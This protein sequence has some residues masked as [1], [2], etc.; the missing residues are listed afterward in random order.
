MFEKKSL[1]KIENNLQELEKKIKELSIQLE[2]A[3]KNIKNFF[4]ETGVSL[5]KLSSYSSNKENFSEE[6][7]R[8]LSD[9][10]QQL[11]DKLKLELTNI[12]NPLKVKRARSSLQV[13]RHW[14]YVR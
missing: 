9:Y 14:L 5:E 3:D 1:E 7:W 10:K 8:K 6:T 13:E 11:D 12:S 2:N 4:D